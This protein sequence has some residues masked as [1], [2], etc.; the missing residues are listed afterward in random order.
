MLSTLQSVFLF[1]FTQ[2]KQCDVIKNTV[3]TRSVSRTHAANIHS[4]MRRL[5]LLAPACV[6]FT[7]VFKYVVN[8]NNSCNLK[9][10]NIKDDDY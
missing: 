9:N 10:S 3:D 7:A 8:N 5:C 1:C 6:Y 2:D 4:Q